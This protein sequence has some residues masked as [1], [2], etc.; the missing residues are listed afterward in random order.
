MILFRRHWK[1]IGKNK[2]GEDFLSTCRIG[3]AFAVI[4][5]YIQFE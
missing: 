4:N 5:I 1:K 2:I 3:S